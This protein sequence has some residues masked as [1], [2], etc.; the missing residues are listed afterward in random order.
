VHQNNALV[1]LQGMV[2]PRLCHIFVLFRQSVHGFL[3]GWYVKQVRG[4]RGEARSNRSQL[5][6]CSRGVLVN[7]S[8]DTGSLDINMLNG[9]GSLPWALRCRAPRIAA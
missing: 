7:R 9:I 4:L 3:I 8:L 5:T 6:D 1:K 2:R